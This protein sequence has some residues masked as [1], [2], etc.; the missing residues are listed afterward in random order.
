MTVIQAALLGL[1][2][3]P[4][5]FYSVIQTLPELPELRTVEKHINHLGFK[6]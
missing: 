4:V 2:M 1:R 5:L 6:A 3:F